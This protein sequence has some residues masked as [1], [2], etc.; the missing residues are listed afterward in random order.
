MREYI[1]PTLILFFAPVLAAQT[2]PSGWLIVKESKGACRMAVPPDWT[3]YGDSG[4]V[5]VFKDSTTALAVVTSQPDQEFKPLPQAIQKVMGIAKDKMFDNSEKRVF[6]QD[7]TSENEDTPN[8][9]SIAVPGRTGTCSAHLTFLPSVSMEV[10]RKIA[11]T[12]G[13]AEPPSN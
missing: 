4:G 9:F 7:R 5:A 12:L 6:Y 3:L 13:P 11:L 1:V 8:A 10:A 2:I